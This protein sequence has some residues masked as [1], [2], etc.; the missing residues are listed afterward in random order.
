MKANGL[1]SVGMPGGQPKDT[2]L[3]AG[4][5]LSRKRNPVT[6]S[7][8]VAKAFNKSHSS[9]L[10]AID[11]LQRDEFN[12][13]NF[14]SITY[15][16]GRNR[17]QRAV[18]MTRA[19]FTYLV[20]SFTGIKAA[21]LK[22]RYI[23][24][25]D[26]MEAQLLGV[27]QLPPPLALASLAQRAVQVQGTKEVAT[28]LLRS[29]AGK[30][31]LIQHHRGVMRCLVGVTPTEYVRAAVATGLRVASCSGRELLRRL[32]PSKAATAAFFD[33]QLRR[34]KTLE[35]LTTA[36]LHEVLPHAFAAMLACGIIPAELSA[37][38]NDGE[39]PA[40]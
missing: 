27:A 1:K 14:A 6:D 13:G 34:G 21:Q 12:R 20:M 19:G 5:Y 38:T 25:F 39:G 11:G 3:A 35:Q 16:D 28:Q 2:H 24:Q 22:Q 10:R 8:R 15:I 33:D 36:R 4:V 32:E 29:S 37:D 17:R 9:V 18:V 23:A 7:R 26:R 31:G 40:E 30:Y